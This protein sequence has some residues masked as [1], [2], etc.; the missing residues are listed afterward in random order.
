MAWIKNDTNPYNLKTFYSNIMKENALLYKYQFIVDFIGLDKYGITDT[1]DAAKN[2][3][4]YIQSASI[5]G[6]QLTN[7]KTVFLGTEFR[8]PG[9]LKFGHQ[10]NTSVLLSQSLFSYKG[11]QN[12][13]RE[14]SRLEIDGGGIKTIPDVQ[15]RVSVLS[16]DHQTIEKSFILE[17]VWIKELGALQLQYTN[18]GSEPL[19]CSVQFRY[20]YVYPDFNGDETG[21]SLQKDP[22]YSGKK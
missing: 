7:G 8:A 19:K 1:T 20:Q 21:T 18:G 11:L 17:G 9:V 5:P 6:Y 10:W 4:Y 12:W 22:L 15:A 14:I 2:I 3:T 13:R 16:S